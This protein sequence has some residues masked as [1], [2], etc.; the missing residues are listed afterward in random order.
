VPTLLLHG[1]LDE[2][3]PLAV[4]HELHASIPGSTLVVM[5][6][7][8]HQCNLEAPDRFSDEVL[9]FLRAARA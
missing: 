1:E 4:A 8:G 6:G 5:S 9:T 3:S 2:R 7:V